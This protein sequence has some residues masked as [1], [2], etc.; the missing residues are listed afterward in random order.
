LSSRENLKEAFTVFEENCQR[1][2]EELSETDSVLHNFSTSRKKWVENQLGKF[3]E[4]IEQFIT[5]F[6]AENPLLMDVEQ[7]FMTDFCE[8]ITQ[9]K[10]TEYFLEYENYGINILSR[11]AK[12][13]ELIAQSLELLSFKEF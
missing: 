7:V 9:N 3:R 13:S 11:C 12:K 1:W 2:I 10:V 8:A 4:I 6:W 5:K